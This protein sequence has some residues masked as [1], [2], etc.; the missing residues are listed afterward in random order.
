MVV[1]GPKYGGRRLGG[2]GGGGGNANAGGPISHLH[3]E[4]WCRW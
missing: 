1:T 4:R 3:Q 2:G